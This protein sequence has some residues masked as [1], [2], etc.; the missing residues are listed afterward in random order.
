[1]HVCLETRDEIPSGTEER[2]RHGVRAA[3]GLA[4]LRTAL[5]RRAAPAPADVMPR[6]ARGTPKRR[7]SKRTGTGCVGPHGRTHVS[8]RAPARFSKANV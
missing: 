5:N 7:C 1:M 3:G 4:A 6:L 8:Q 2:P